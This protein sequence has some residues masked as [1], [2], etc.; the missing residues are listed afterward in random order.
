MPK[1]DAPKVGAIL[2]ADDHEVFRFGLAEVLRVA[3]GA[4]R[5]I[6]VGTFQAALDALSDPELAL[7]I[8][9]LRI[10]GLDDPHLL[11]QIR[12]RRP[13]LRVIVLSGS[14][15]REDILAALEAGVHGYIVKNECTQKLVE[16]IQSIMSGEIYVPPSIAELNSGGHRQQVPREQS[17]GLTERQLQVLALIAQGHSNK[18]IAKKLSIAESTVK[19]HIAATFR[20]IGAKNR[21]QAAAIY[22]KLFE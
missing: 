15:H 11:A 1:R 7:A 21:T 20:A 9:D 2:I 22:K 16:R 3:M 14:P 4:S 5:V 17:H 13:D 19:M 18:A 6:S 10:P 12:H 8:C